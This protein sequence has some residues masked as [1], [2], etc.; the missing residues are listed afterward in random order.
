MNK[1]P[2]IIITNDDGINAKGIK[3]L[4][5][6]LY[7]ICNIFIIAPYNFKSGASHSVTIK[8]NIVL[9]KIK[10]NKKIVYIVKGT[11]VDCIKLAIFKLKKIKPALVISGI[12]HGPNFGKFIHYSGTVGAAAEAAFHN[13]P[14]IAISYDDFDKNADFYFAKKIIKVIVK[15]I[16]NKKIKIKKGTFL[17]INIPKTN[18]I[19]GVKI[20]SK[21]MFNYNE[22]YKKI[23][24]NNKIYYHWQVND[25]IFENNKLYDDTALRKGY[26]T[27]TPISLNISDKKEIQKFKKMKI[28]NI[29]MK[30]IIQNF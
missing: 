2:Y 29:I 12:N 26:V 16:L 30:E 5:D 13:I 4:Y 3:E 8:D 17:N 19:K 7:D 28:E 14:S 6:A 15:N 25:K 23:K 24:K 20:L 22:K 21:S 10:F 9:K 27:I 11:P 1:K 18:D